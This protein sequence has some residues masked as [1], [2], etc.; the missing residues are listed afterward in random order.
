MI[1][2]TFSP[3]SR[4]PLS[5]VTVLLRTENRLRAFDAEATDA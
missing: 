2:L 5:L 3:P 1:S 4:L